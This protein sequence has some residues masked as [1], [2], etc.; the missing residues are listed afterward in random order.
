MK[1]IAIV[2]SYP[3]TIK[4]LAEQIEMLSRTFHVSVVLNLPARDG[5]PHLNPGVDVVSAPI[6]RDIS[7]LRDLQG[8]IFL[9]ALFSR[10]Q[11]DAVHSITPKAGLLAAL[12]GAIARVPVRIHTFTGQVWATRA[13]LARQ[14]LKTAD[15]VIARLTTHILVDSPSQR[16]FLIREGVLSG[17]KSNVLA[18]GSLWGVNVSRFRPDAAWRIK[19]RQLHGIPEEATLFLFVGRLKID[20]GVLD[21]ANAFSQVAESCCEAWLLFVGPDEEQLSSAIETACPA[22]GNRLRL[23]GSTDVPEEYM[24]AADV[25]CLPSYR[26][27]FG[28]VIIEAASAGI[29][30]VASNIYGITDAIE[31]GE[32]GLMH[33]VGDVESL[34]RE[35]QKMI[36][37]PGMRNALGQK[38]KL[39][40]HRLFASDLVTSALVEFYDSVVG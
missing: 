9:V 15:R 34:R 4:A 39:R 24:A 18:N 10:Q 17:K 31:P 8:L 37:D 28:S 23:V 1:K 20:K 33:A 21:L 2:V 22:A 11:F 7:L 16:D 19:I 26:E 30:S 40:A 14:V 27:G 12:S 36:D 3:G 29:P 32:T 25:F 6:V 38:A 5:L 13:G 35:M